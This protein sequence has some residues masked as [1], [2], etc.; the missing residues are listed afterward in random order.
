MAYDLAAHILLGPDQ[1][2]FYFLTYGLFA[3]LATLLFGVPALFIYRFFRV[4][5]VILFV[6]GGAVIG[7]IVSLFVMESYPYSYFINRMPERLMCAAAGALSALAFRLLLPPD[8]SPR[9]I[10]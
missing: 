7:F 8:F 9:K 5:N 10:G 6:I 2:P 1:I 4:S 3:Y